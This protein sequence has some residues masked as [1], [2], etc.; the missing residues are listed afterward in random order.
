MVGCQKGLD[1]LPS[2][3]CCL[4][5]LQSTFG[6]VKKRLSYCYAGDQHEVAPGQTPGAFLFYV[7]FCEAIL[8]LVNHQAKAGKPYTPQAE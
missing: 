6:L 3:D 7:S 1:S 8:I 4:E 5:Y 2:I